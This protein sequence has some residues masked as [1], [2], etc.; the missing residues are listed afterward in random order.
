MKINFRKSSLKR[1]LKRMLNANWTIIGRHLFS[2]WVSVIETFQW[3]MWIWMYWKSNIWQIITSPTPVKSKAVNSLVFQT[4][5]NISLYY[6]ITFVLTKNAFVIFTIKRTRLNAFWLIV[7]WLFSN[8]CGLY[9]LLNA[10]RN[11]L[12]LYNC[13]YSGYSNSTSRIDIQVKD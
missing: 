1:S 11:W 12:N 8:I 9:V 4:L 7:T 13:M 3:Y 2:W 5:R 10:S 6:L